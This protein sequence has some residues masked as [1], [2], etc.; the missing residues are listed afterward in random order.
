MFVS[1]DQYGQRF[2][3]VP[4]SNLLHQRGTRSPEVILSADNRSVRISHIPRFVVCCLAN[5]ALH[6][7]NIQDDVL[8]L[9]D[10]SDTST[11]RISADANLIVHALDIIERDLRERIS[12]RLQAVHGGQGLVRVRGRVTTTSRASVSSQTRRQLRRIGRR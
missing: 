6:L 1:S 10:V 7:T 8:R 9:R 3:C 5:L 12:E 2:N 4:L 11:S